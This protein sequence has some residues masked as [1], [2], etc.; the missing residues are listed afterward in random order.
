MSVWRSIRT[1]EPDELVDER[2]VIA[3]ARIDPA[4]F[5]PLYEQHSQVVYR[6][7]YRATGNPELAND[8]TAHVFIT[9]IERLNRYEPISGA[10]FRSWLMQI[11]R[12]GVVDHWRRNRRLVPLAIDADDRIDESPGPEDI[13]MH[14]SDLAAVI[15]AMNALPERYRDV[16]EFRLSGLSISEIATA[17]NVTESAAK[18]IQTRAFRHIRAEL[19]KGGE[20]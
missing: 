8:L 11:A 5:A 14:R 20:G 6:L 1:T 3:A 10:T 15:D 2:E 17:M 12:N 4:A 13:A 18:S 7:C 19:M 16:L 9:A